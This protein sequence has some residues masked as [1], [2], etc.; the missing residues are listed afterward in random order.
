M[1]KEDGIY[2]QYSVGTYMGKE[3]EMEWIYYPS[4]S[5][6]FIPETNTTL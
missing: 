1:G 6:C 2:T 5:L 4:D 3:S